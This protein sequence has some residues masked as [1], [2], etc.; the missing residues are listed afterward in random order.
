MGRLATY[1]QMEGR[2][3]NKTHRCKR[4]TWLHCTVF[5]LSIIPFAILGA[6]LQKG[7]SLNDHRLSV[8]VLPVF[9]KPYVVVSIC[10]CIMIVLL[11]LTC[12]NVYM[13]V[14]RVTCKHDEAHE[15]M[16]YSYESELSFDGLDNGTMASYTPRRN[17]LA[18]QMARNS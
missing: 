18:L 6:S 4:S 1:K 13:C 14:C 8:F 9:L 17:T 12:V 15:M 5:V 16:E 7:G 3:A 10:T 11:I 2:Y